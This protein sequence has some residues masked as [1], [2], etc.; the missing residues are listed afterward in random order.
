MPIDCR[1]DD[2][3]IW[4]LRGIIEVSVRIKINSGE[5]RPFALEVEQFPKQVLLEKPDKT[6]AVLPFGLFLLVMLFF[7][8]DLAVALGLGF[9]LMCLTAFA[10]WRG[11]RPYVLNFETDKVLVSEPGLFRDRDWQATYS[12]YEGVFQRSRTARSGAANTT[13]QIIELQ[14]PE[15][16][17]TLPLY[18]HKTTGKP[19]GSLAAYAKLFGLPARGEDD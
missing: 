2:R 3:E 12:E 5:D 9:A 8:F 10:Y 18:V 16:E 15:S 14:H 7:V 1:H 6:L 17:K 13:Y 4:P 19:I 11:K